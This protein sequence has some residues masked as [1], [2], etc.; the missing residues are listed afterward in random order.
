MRR[1]AALL[2]V[3][4]VGLA[5]LA[6][7]AKE[8]LDRLQGTWSRASA[9][10]NGKPTPEDELKKTTLII[11]GDHYTLRTPEGDRRGTIKLDPTKSP[12][13]V[14][15]IPSEGPNKGKTLAGIYELDGDTLRYCLTLTGKERPTEFASK[16]GSGQGLFV[17]K[18][19][20]R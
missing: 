6:S 15:L 10:V 12:K 1:F 9:E 8:D 16:P 11:E 3:L 18:R 19:A 13:Q 20:R 7:D 14:D 17:N 2:V 5:A 4:S